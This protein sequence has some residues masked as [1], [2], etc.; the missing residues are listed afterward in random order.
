MSARLLRL[1]PLAALALLLGASGCGERYVT[2]EQAS[3]VEAPLAP[4]TLFQLQDVP[5]P[6]ILSYDRGISLKAQDASGRIAGL[7]YGGRVHPERAAN[8]FVEQMPKAGWKPRTSQM[9]GSRRHIMIFTKGKEYCVISVERR[10]MGT[11]RV[12]IDVH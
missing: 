9:A 12:T 6:A 5:V 4:A 11:V 7:V 10:A 3:K 2:E 1:A 8:F